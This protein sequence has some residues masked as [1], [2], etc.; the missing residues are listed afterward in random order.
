MM[1]PR[2]CT[3]LSTVYIR[4]H[5]CKEEA[6]RDVWGGGARGQSRNVVVGIFERCFEKQLESGVSE[7]RSA[8]LTSTAA[9]TDSSPSRAT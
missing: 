2:R 8:L 7:T 3:G 9:R 6:D 5:H 4:T 1:K